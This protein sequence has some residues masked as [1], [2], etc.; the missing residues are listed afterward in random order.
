MKYPDCFFQLLCQVWCISYFFCSRHSYFL[1]DSPEDQVQFQ[2]CNSEKHFSGLLW[3]LFGHGGTGTVASCAIT[4]AEWHLIYF[5]FIDYLMTD[6]TFTILRSRNW[7]QCHQNLI[8]CCL[9]LTIRSFFCF[10]CGLWLKSVWTVGRLLILK[11]ELDP[12]VLF[13]VWNKVHENSIFW[14]HL[15]WNWLKDFKWKASK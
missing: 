15:K 13:K 1:K 10:L 2:Y 5:L 14:I 8:H 3:S 6:S 11:Q 7:S 9:K 4:W 12:S